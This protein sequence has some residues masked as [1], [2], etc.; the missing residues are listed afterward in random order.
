[1]K[2]INAKLVASFCM[3][4]AFAAAMIPHEPE[5]SRNLH[6]E[7][8]ER[9]LMDNILRDTGINWTWTSWINGPS[10]PSNVDTALE[11]SDVDLASEA[12]QK[13]FKNIDILGNSCI[14]QSKLLKWKLGIN[15]GVVYN[16]KV[17]YNKGFGTVSKD[18]EVKPSGDTIFSIGSVTKIF[19]SHM[20]ANLVEKGI[21]SFEDPVSKFYNEQAPPVF[22]PINPYGSKRHQSVTLR[23]LSTHTSGLPREPICSISEECTEEKIFRG[24]GNSCLLAKPLTSP[25]YSNLGTAL[26]SH[27]LERAYNRA[28][29]RDI[30]YEEWLKE[31][32]FDVLGMSDSGFSVNES[33]MERMAVGYNVDKDN[34]QIID[35][36]YMIKLGWSNGCGGMYSTM[37]DM[38]A[39]VK[40]VLEGDKSRSLGP[41]AYEY[42]TLPGVNFPDGLSSFGLG[43]WEA[44]YANG[45]HTLTKSG[46]IGGFGTSISL[47]P[48]LKLG[49]VTWFNM[50]SGFTPSQVNSL[51][52]GQVISAVTSELRKKGS[53]H[54]LPPNVD[55][56]VGKYAFDGVT[57]FTVEKQSEDQKVGFLKGNLLSYPVYY[58]YD[59]EYTEAMKPYGDIIGLRV[60]QVPISS[61]ME[62]CLVMYS[63]GVDM[64]LLVIQKVDGKYFASSQDFHIIGVPKE[65]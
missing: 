60:R 43:T 51:S 25:R 31:N 42:Y 52:L 38:L 55:E 24:I 17:I 18:S 9:K 53:E 44:F 7:R 15:I 46:L 28:T 40:D 2:T 26:L 23:S 22:A 29:G 1:M 4:V 34:K 35:S 20:L 61:A 45:Y 57:Y 36:T 33:S 58:S 48:S 8:I 10:C 47:V 12:V 65:Q 54:P 39:F 63:G 56:I 50:M 32:V 11:V 41:D 62:S 21:V 59:E 3:V 30:T 16:G 19:T 13:A 27:C 37:N 64:G 14:S 49:V 5:L 6:M